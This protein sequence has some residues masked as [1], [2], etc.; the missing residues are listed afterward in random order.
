[1]CNGKGKLIHADNDI[2]EGDWVDNRANGFGIY[3]H[4]EGAVNIYLSNL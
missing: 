2:Y 3:R 1:M 4:A